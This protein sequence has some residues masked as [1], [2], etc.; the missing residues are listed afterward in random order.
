VAEVLYGFG[1]AE[2]VSLEVRWP[3]G[4]VDAFEG[5]EVRRSVIVHRED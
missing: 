4:R 1:A 3:D 5:V 2:R